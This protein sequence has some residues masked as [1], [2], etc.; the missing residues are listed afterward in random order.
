[1]RSRS[2]FRGSVDSSLKAFARFLPHAAVAAGVRRF[3]F[4]A[5]TLDGKAVATQVTLQMNF[6]HTAGD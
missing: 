4:V 1:M 3:H 2:S 5:A 6:H